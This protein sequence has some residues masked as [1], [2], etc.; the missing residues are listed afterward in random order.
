[1][2]PP[3]AFGAALR[4]PV[5]EAFGVSALLFLRVARFLAVAMSPI[6]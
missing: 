2:P 1:L 4:L 6:G 3:F 5:L